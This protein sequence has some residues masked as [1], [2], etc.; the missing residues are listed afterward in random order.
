[1]ELDVYGI[2]I[3]RNICI[4]DKFIIYLV[5]IIIVIKKIYFEIFFW[6]WGKREVKN[7]LMCRI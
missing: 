5:L 4:F 1:M 7:F 6:I 3:F 2:K